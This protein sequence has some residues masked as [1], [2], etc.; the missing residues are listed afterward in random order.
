MNI[1]ISNF[2]MIKIKLKYEKSSHTKILE[3]KD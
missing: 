1:Y 3:N 2:N